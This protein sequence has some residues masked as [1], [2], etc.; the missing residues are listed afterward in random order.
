MST[1]SYTKKAIKRIAHTKGHADLDIKQPVHLI[2]HN[3][4]SRSGCAMS[5][6]NHAEANAMYAWFGVHD[7]D[8][9]R[10]W[11]YVAAK[12]EQMLYLMDPDTI[13]PGGKTLRLMMPLL[14]NNDSLIDWF[15]HYD[16]AYDMKRVE[17]HKTHDFWAYQA[18]LALRGE[19][20]RLIERCERIIA[21]PP[22]ASAEK[23]YLVDHHFYLA[24]ARRDTGKMQEALA[25]LVTPY[26][27]V[28]E[29]SG[30]TEDL[31]STAAVVYA[32]I[33]WRHGYHVQVDSPYIPAEW[34]P[35]EPLTQYSNHYSFLK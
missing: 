26:P 23:K 9:M 31:I 3:Q 30:F 12:L 35:I 25:Q 10:Q 22:G 19:W 29:G 2:E 13:S 32:K 28:G 1:K 5:L 17:S 18:M 4:G 7:L 11:C 6:S 20:D 24:L 27:R 33:A 34:L 14:S 8:A 15:A 16:Q 21:D